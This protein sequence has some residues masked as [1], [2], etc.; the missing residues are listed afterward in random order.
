MSWAGIAL[1][2]LARR[3]AAAQLPR[4]RAADRELDPGQRAL[5]HRAGRLRLRADPGLEGFKSAEHNIDV[6]AFFR[7]IAELTGDQIWRPAAPSTPGT[8]WSGCGTPRTATSGPAPTTAPP[9]T[10]AATQRPLD[11]QTWT[12][13]AARQSRYAEALDW[14]ATNLAVTDTP[15]RTNSDADRERSV[16][17]GWRS[18]AGRCKADTETPDRQV[19]PRQPGHRSGLV[20]GHRAAGARPAGP[21]PARRPRQGR[22]AD[23]RDPIRP[24]ENL[25]A[26]PDV[27][28]Q[29]DPR[30]HRRRLVA[31]GHR[32]RLRL[33][34]A[35]ARRRDLLVRDAP[36]NPH[37]P[38]RV[39][40]R[41]PPAA[42]PELWSQ[43]AAMGHRSA[44][45]WTT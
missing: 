7:L 44:P 20:R 41:S 10:R 17:P 33:L 24:S 26:R 14:A 38:V 2:Q 37:R 6:Y 39:P 12:W 3:T 21:R 36:S 8:S 13:L 34:P 9:S 43:T 1:A 42:S 27:Q 25:G 11:V 35:P 30:R 19:L 40:R 15:Q 29:G 22:R 31:A 5:D 28:R 16:S 23:G 45:V 32:L 4:R 18:A